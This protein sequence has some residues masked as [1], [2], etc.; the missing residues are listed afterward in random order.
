MEHSILLLA[1]SLE[2]AKAKLGFPPGSN[3]TP[4][5]VKEAYRRKA[6]ESHPD[7]GGDEDAIKEINVAKDILDG[8]ARPTYDRRPSGPSRSPW[9]TEEQQT[10]KPYE[11]PKKKEVSFDDAKAKAGIPSGVDWLFVT[12][13]QRG[14]GYS[15]DEFHRE[16]VAFVAYG[17]TANQHVFVGY[18]HEVYEQYFVGA[19]PG[20]DIWTIRSFEYPIK[21]EAKESQNPAWLYG[22]VVR[23]LK[24]LESKGKFNS[25]VLDAKGWKFGD[26]LPSGAA[27]SI[28][29]WLVGSGQV[30]GDAPSVA[31]RK[32]VVELQLDKSSFG[33]QKPGFW[34][35]PKTRANFWDGS[36]HGDY[37]KITVILNGKP[38]VLD[39]Q[40]TTKFLGKIPLESIYGRYYYGGEKKNLTRMP[41]GKAIIEWMVQNFSL[42]SEEA[43]VGLQAAADQMKGSYNRRTASEVRDSLHEEPE[44]LDASRYLEHTT[45]LDPKAIF[46]YRKNQAWELRVSNAATASKIA[47]R[48]HH[49]LVSKAKLTSSDHFFHHRKLYV[50]YPG[51]YVEQDGLAETKRDTG[52]A[53]LKRKILSKGEAVFG[54]H[55]VKLSGSDG[56]YKLAILPVRKEFRGKFSM[57]NVSASTLVELDQMLDKAINK[58]KGFL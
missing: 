46:Y 56:A 28:K 4:Q 55:G 19:G 31:G 27:T 37:Y 26:R 43:M 7:R 8:K 2:E 35:Q 52:R 54:S 15:S 45:E 53:D 40:D 30:Q 21:D 48:A 5:E 1:M 23:A 18:K 6:L 34:P 39:E 13:P 36:Y 12:P 47:K 16:D 38:Y 25:K 29:H 32:Q 33:E 22:N 57:T 9:P 44:M 14:V 24:E 42:P 50:S 58:V 10:S 41:K 51:G 49:D 11:Q 17:R 20:S 3:P